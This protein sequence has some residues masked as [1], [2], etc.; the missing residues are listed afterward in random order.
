LLGV[1]DEVKYWQADLRIMF[2]GQE[3]Q[4]GAGSGT[5]D[6]LM[7][8]YCHDYNDFSGIT[9]RGPFWWYATKMR[10]AINM[11]VPGKRVSY[12]WNNIIKADYEGVKNWKVPSPVYRQ[13]RDI[14]RALILGEVEILKPHILIF[15]TGGE[16]SDQYID[17]VFGKDT[18]KTD[19]YMNGRNSV[20]AKAHLPVYSVPA[21]GHQPTAEAYISYHPRGLLYLGRNVYEQAK[22][23]LFSSVIEQCK[24]A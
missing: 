8:K 22:E 4:N 23:K 15:L 2:F 18:N 10:D 13:I 12:I 20:I 3:T 11:S 7:N 24:C 16:G 5:I 1:S 21:A 9:D 14:N 17:Y 6:E 19:I